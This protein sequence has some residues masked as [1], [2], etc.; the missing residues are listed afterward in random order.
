MRPMR[1]CIVCVQPLVISVVQLEPAPEEADPFRR[2]VLT[3]APAVDGEG[4]K[5]K[6]GAIFD[7]RVAW[8]RNKVVTEY[9]ISWKGYLWPRGGHELHSEGVSK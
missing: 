1:Q 4:N 9:L 3:R 6:V 8:C 5:Y 7:K 2:P